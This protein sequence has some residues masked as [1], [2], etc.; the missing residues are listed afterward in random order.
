MC[1]GFSNF[2]AFLHHFVLT[3][4]KRVRFFRGICYNFSYFCP[5]QH[6]SEKSVGGGGGGG[7]GNNRGLLSCLVEYGMILLNY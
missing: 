4:T 6:F 1:Q 5:F 7:G 3:N 2:S